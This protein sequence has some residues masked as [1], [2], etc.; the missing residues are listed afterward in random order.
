MSSANQQAVAKIAATNPLLTELVTARDALGLAD[1]EL[2]HAGPPFQPG[3]EPPVVV[4]NALAGAAVHEGWAGDMDQGRAMVRAGEIKLHTN[5]SLG[6]VSPMAG[7]VRPSQRLFRVVDQASGISTFATLAEKGRHVLRFGYYTPEVAAGLAYVE[8]VVA[9]AIAKALPKGGLPVLPLVARGVELGDD[10]HQR[11]VGGML[12]FLAALPDLPGDVRAWMA[13]HPQHFLNYAMASAKLSLDQARGTVSSSVVTAI[14][15]N[16]LV[17]G[18]QLAGTDD[19]WFNAP[20]DLP[21]GGFY[22]PFTI[23]DAHRDLGD[24]AIME[25]FGL[26]GC[27]AHVS[28]EIARSMQ[29]PWSEA[30][31]A[32]RGMRSLFLSASTIITPALAGAAAAGVGLDARRV[33]ASNEGVRIHTGIAH[34]DGVAGWIGIGVAR[35]PLE[36]F[37]AGLAKLDSMING[38]TR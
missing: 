19:E 25:A 35:A 31:E 28:P 15:R 17:C 2:G 12:A 8:G 36:C 18:V 6:T 30:V 34:R 16:G 24:S 7:V 23:D 1:G 32:G 3:E 26:G 5:H 27:I 14:S 11:N 22:P 33:A 9:E 20:A 29:R 10:V 38:Q 21:R 13:D 4:L 37:T